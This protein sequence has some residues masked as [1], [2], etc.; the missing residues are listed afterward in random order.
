MM[1]PIMLRRSILVLGLMAALSPGTNVSAAPKKAAKTQAVKA[2]TLALSVP[3][4]WEQTQPSSSMR[5]AQFRIP[6]A[7]GDTEDGEFVVFFFGAGGGGGVNANL[8]RWIAQFEPGG[9]TVDLVQ[10]KSPK[11]DYIF[12][13]ITGTYNMPI[14]P[15]MNGQ[16]KPVANAQVLAAIVNTPDGA[17][18]LKAWGGKKTMVGAAI[19]LRKSFGAKAAGEKLYKM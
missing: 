2:G 14:G 9:R 5:A 19:D 10:G 8:D 12:A 1:G 18:F 4:A 6:A 11:G 3:G 15:A 16:S 13:T 17:Y 7:K